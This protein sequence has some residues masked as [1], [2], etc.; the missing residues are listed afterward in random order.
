M[1]PP[2]LERLPAMELP[3]P[4]TVFYSECGRF[5]PVPCR[6]R[7]SARFLPMFSAPRVAP[8]F[9][10]I[11][12]AAALTVLPLGPAAAQPA[13]PAPAGSARSG[14]PGPP[15]PK[16]IKRIDPTSDGV[17]VAAWHYAAPEAAPVV[18]TVLL[19]HDLG[20]SHLTVEPLAKA[21]QAAGCTVVVPDLRGHGES[22][23]PRPSQGD[24][25][26]TKSLRAPD[27]MM[28]AT[29]SGGQIRDQA[30]LRG[31][32]ECLRPWLKRGM[33]EGEIPRAPLFV[34]GS[35]LGAV[36][37]SAWTSADARWP[38]V[39]SGPQGREV[40]GLVLISPPFVAK[41]I[42]F[43]PLLKSDEIG[44][45]LPILMIAGRGDRDAVKVFDTLKRQRPDSW[46]DSRVPPGDDRGSSPA[47]PEDA[48]LLMFTGQA[49][50]SGDELAA[51]RAARGDPASLILAF[52][53]AV[54]A[55]AE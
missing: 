22:R 31:D 49:D 45:G 21:L 25:D 20:G 6:P 23:L 24:A 51:M 14:P 16:R 44:R 43:A 42:Q 36:L 17:E 54:K 26:P 34:V 32:I 11:G 19:V 9:L 53:K 18:A 52:V 38:D 48:T 1:Q 41:G 28:I 30:G 27:L 39:A 4:D 40:A 5:R 2:A 8:A 33:A 47:R 46:F 37:G 13:A 50:R 29:S 7:P 35:G 10:A 12:T 55:R 3:G 15:A